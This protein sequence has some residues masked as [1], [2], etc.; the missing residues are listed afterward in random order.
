MDPRAARHSQAHALVPVA[1]DFDSP[2]PPL[3]LSL[4]TLSPSLQCKKSTHPH[5]A[6]PPSSRYHNSVIMQCDL[7]RS[8]GGDSRFA[9]YLPLAAQYERGLAVPSSYSFTCASSPL[10][11]PHPRPH[12][13][14]SES[15]CASTSLSASESS[16]ARPPTPITSTFSD[17]T[18]TSEERQYFVLAADPPFP[19]D[20]AGLDRAQRAPHAPCTIPATPSRFRLLLVPDAEDYVNAKEE[21]DPCA[22]L[23]A[24]AP[25]PSVFPLA[26][27]VRPT[28]HINAAPSHRP[29]RALVARVCAHVLFSLFPHLRPTAHTFPI[30]TLST[31]RSRRRL[32]WRSSSPLPLQV[33]RSATISTAPAGYYVYAL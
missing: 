29:F 7:C 17:S 9:P 8:S 30:A 13:R 20:G 16:H 6:A 23:D 4:C 3:A 12:P 18:S 33:P 22:G 26:G 31:D 19:Y 15:P 2:A 24:R 32:P 21:G 11:L 1:L 5:C 10:A 27:V 25:L 28:A 14:A